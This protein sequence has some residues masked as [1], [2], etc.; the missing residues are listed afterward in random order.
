METGAFEEKSSHEKGKKGKGKLEKSKIEKRYFRIKVIW[1]LGP[2][3]RAQ[4]WYL[5]L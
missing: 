2:V 4:N 5:S 3:T 1:D